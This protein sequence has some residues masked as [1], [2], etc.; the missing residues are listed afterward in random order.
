MANYHRLTPQERY[1]IAAL[2]DSGIAIRRI[3]RQLNRS[4]STILRE[5]ERNRE[6]Q[7]YKPQCAQR[8]A[9]ERRIGVG[10]KKKIKG[11]L[12]KKIDKCLR[13]QWSPEQIARDLSLNKIKLSPETI[14]QYVYGD[15]KTGGKLYINLRR[16]RKYRRTRKAL[17]NCRNLGKRL[18]HISIDERPRIV[19]ERNRIGDFERDTML[20]KFGSPV[21]LTIVDRT[22]RLIRM[23]KVAKINAALTHKATL[24]LLKKSVVETITNDNGPEF[25][26]H[27]KTAQALKTKVYFNHPYCSWERGTNEN[28]NG[29]VRQY[30]PKGFDFNLVTAA[31]IKLIETKLNNRPRKCLGFKTPIQIHKKLSRVLR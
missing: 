9:G 4:A 15:R 16:G 27:K 3:A 18:D 29:L 31:E 11:S 30:Y 2:K 10:P 13:E 8:S 21:L 7:K 23:T 22:T 20:G 19:E 26:M 6:V 24:K 25:A 1:Q 5:I 28:T 17:Y 14:Y 12:K